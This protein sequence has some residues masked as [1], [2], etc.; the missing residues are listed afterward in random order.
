MHTFESYKT[1]VQNVK[2]NFYPLFSTSIL[3][4]IRSYGDVIQLNRN[5]SRIKRISSVRF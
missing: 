5:N 1:V 2:K 3:C 4:R